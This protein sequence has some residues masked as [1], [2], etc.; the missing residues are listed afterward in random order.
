MDVSSNEPFEVN[1]SS[2]LYMKT[3]YS[4]PFRKSLFQDHR[5]QSNERADHNV[6]NF[7]GILEANETFE[8]MSS[9]RS[10]V[11]QYEKNHRKF[12]SISKQVI[13][14]EYAPTNGA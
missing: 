4:V 10:L 6:D 2:T 5:S 3:Y 1:A 12:N 11:T 7:V 14:L 9:W 8:K 13:V